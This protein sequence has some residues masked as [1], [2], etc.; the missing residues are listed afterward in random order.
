MVTGDLKAVLVS[1][2]EYGFEN[3]LF[4]KKDWHQNTTPILIF[5]KEVSN[6]AELDYYV[7]IANDVVTYVNT[8]NNGKAF[9]YDICFF[10][11]C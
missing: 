10:E 8:G 11:K 6:D 7:S 3:R 9:D 2:D 5:N 4:P 1:Y